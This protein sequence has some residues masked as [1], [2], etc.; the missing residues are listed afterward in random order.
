LHFI[1]AFRICPD[2]ASGF[3]AADYRRRNKTGDN[4]SRTTPRPAA[5]PPIEEDVVKISTALIQLDVVVTDKN[6]NLIADLKPEDFEVTENGERQAITALSYFSGRKYSTPDGSLNAVEGSNQTMPSIGEVR[7]TVAVV[8]DDAGLSAQSINLVKKELVKFISEQV[9]PNDLVAI[10]KTSGSVGVLQQFTT[11]KEKLLATVENLRYQP[12]T[13]SGLSPFAPIS[14]S[15]AEQ[16]QNNMGGGELSDK[17]K[18]ILEQKTNVEFLNNLN[19]NIVVTAG[20]LGVLNSTI[21]AMSRMPGRKSVLYVAEGVFSLFDSA[22]PGSMNNRN[23]KGGSLAGLVNSQSTSSIFA[24]SRELEEKLRG[25]TEIANRATIAVY[26]LDPRG[27]AA[28]NFSASDQMRGGIT[29]R[30]G[31][32]LNEND[33]T[34]R[35]NNFRASQLGLKFLSDETSGKAFINTNDIGKGLRETL[36]SQ[37]GYYILAYQ[38]DTDTFDAGKRRFNKLSV[39]VKRSNVNVSYR[40]GF[41]NVAE[42]AEEKS[43]ETPE[44]VFLQRLFSPYKYNDID[45]RI[46]SIYAVDEQAATVRSFIGIE[47]RSLQFA[48]GAD[49]SKTAQFDVVAVAFNEDGIPISQV[50]KRFDLKVSQKGYEKLLADGIASSLSFATKVKG[51]QQVKVA[52]RDVNTNKI[53]TASQTVNVPN[54]DKDSLSLSGVLLQNYTMT[55]WQNAQGGKSSLSPTDVANRM[56]ANTA[57]RQFKKGTVLSFNYAVYSAPSLRSKSQTQFTVFKDGKEVFKG[58]PEELN[59]APTGKMQ[60]INRGGAFLLG[61]DMAAGKY[62]LQ[63]SVSGDGVKQSETQQIDFELTN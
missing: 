50:G 4:A 48:D 21:S 29:D 55:E 10:I 18:A 26:T 8:V 16:I 32:N 51:A 59:I 61:T 38:P 40:S 52:V 42:T 43:A 23:A 28:I 35:N 63:I 33:M 11:D 9:Q 27:T 57:R 49:G 17:S 19:K 2:T 1:R 14:I 12:L 15:F 30:E 46:A 47:P 5:T 58:S 13:G 56:Q 7:R 25:I 31:G 45:L 6:G 36:D 3:D 54:F 60:R 22:N 37:N 62:V 20:A 44:R 34:S 53:G 24:N 41:F 39:K